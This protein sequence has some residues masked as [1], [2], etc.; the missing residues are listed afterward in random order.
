MNPCD[1][2]LEKLTLHAYGDLSPA[3]AR[4]VDQHLESCVGCRA[5]HGALLATLQALDSRLFYPQ[6]GEVDWNLFAAE[7]AGLATGK[8]VPLRRRLLRPMALARAA[9]V[10]LAVGLGWFVLQNIDTTK[11]GPV[12]LPSPDSTNTAGR[13]AQDTAT[14][15]PVDF[16]RRLEVNMARQDTRQYLADT[17]NVLLAVLGSPV[18]CEKDQLDIRLEREK[19]LQLLRRNQFLRD[20]LERPELARAADL[21][22]RLAGILTEISTLDN[23]ADVATIREL[24]DVVKRNQLLIKIGVAEKELGGKSV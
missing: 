9:A 20:D 10:V 21:C 15:M 16:Q 13:A 23:C 19:S 11:V 2:Y 7:T 4:E 22:A 6:E 18:R 3:E 17:R 12:R 5:E 1:A 8:V 24:R 14:V